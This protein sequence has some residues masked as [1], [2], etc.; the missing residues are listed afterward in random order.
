MEKKEGQEEGEVEGDAVL[1]FHLHHLLRTSHL[2]ASREGVCS[3]TG[4]LLS[5]FF[6]PELGC[7]VARREAFVEKMGLV[8]VA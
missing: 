4:D 2:L 7:L 8:E 5:L 1:S 3:H 6:L